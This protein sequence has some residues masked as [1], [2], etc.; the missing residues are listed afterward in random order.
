MRDP[1]RPT[2]DTAAA[3]ST[4]LVA[5]MFERQYVSQYAASSGVMVSP[6]ENSNS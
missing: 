5:G 4:S 3:V 6:F 1:S 2:R